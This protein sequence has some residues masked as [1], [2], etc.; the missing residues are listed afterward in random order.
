[1]IFEETK[2]RGAFVLKPEKREDDRGFF[3]RTF[4]ANEFITH[5]LNPVF[6]QGNMSKTLKKHTLRGMHYQIDGAEEEKLVR[7]TRGALYDVILDVRKDSPT[8]G[9][10]YSIEL[11]EEN[12]FQLYIP[13]GFAH[14]FCTLKDNTEIAY[15]VTEF[16][17]PGKEAGIRWNDP[18]FK[19]KW[20][21]STPDMSDRDAS[22]P[23]FKLS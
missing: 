16:Y 20:P 19:I 4:C 15:M 18:F 5:H 6:V 11:S 2:L 22:Y 14:G 3:A 12:A 23:D 9:Q 7:C 8:F 13:K 21:T 10:Y 1:M 17:T